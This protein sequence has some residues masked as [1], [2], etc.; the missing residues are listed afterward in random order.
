MKRNDTEGNRIR[1]SEEEKKKRN[2]MRRL[3]RKQIHKQTRDDMA[4]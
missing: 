2:E 3:Q 4:K 1:E